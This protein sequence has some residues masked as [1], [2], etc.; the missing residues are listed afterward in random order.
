M[1]ARER[2]L[3]V[4][5][6]AVVIALFVVFI[7]KGAIL[8]PLDELRDQI[9]AQEDQRRNLKRDIGT[10]QAVSKKI[11]DLS[12]RLGKWQK[13]SLPEG[14]HRPEAF[15]THLTLM[16][17]E[18]QKYLS[19]LLRECNFKKLTINSP[20]WDREEPTNA[21]N[22]KPKDFRTL[23][24]NVSGE[25]ELGDIV[26]FFTKFY[27]TNLLH[28]IKSF[29]LASQQENNRGRTVRKEIGIKK[30][31]IEVLLV[32][33]AEP[34]K[35]PGAKGNGRETLLPTFTGK[36]KDVAPKILARPAGSYAEIANRNMFVPR[37]AETII[38]TGP[39]SE[40]KDEVDL[41]VQLT[42]LSASDYYGCW[43]ARIFN[44]GNKDDSALLVDRELP[45]G[46]RYQKD[47]ADYER[48]RLGPDGDKDRPPVPVRKWEVVDR[49]KIK[50]HELEVVRIDERGVV[51]K[52]DGKLYAMQVGDS[53]KTLLEKPLD[54]KAM[55]ELGLTA[56][57]GDVLKK[58]RLAELKQNKGRQGQGWEAV[59]VNGNDGDKKKP[60]SLD[61]LPEEF[62]PPTEWAL[63]DHLGADVVKL[64]VVY[65]DKGRVVFKADKKYYAVKP[66]QN[67][68]DALAKPL[69]DADVK[70]LKLPAP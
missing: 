12:P 8:D 66:G 33:G 1:T 10:E 22:R 17:V 59:F 56:P 43:V 42:M 67:L 28:Q 9:S 23:T 60:L 14:D 70:A 40:P 30:M 34:L 29:T 47:K 31:T 27:G 4:V 5:L 49:N 35:K 15:Q 44:K 16:S 19:K 62:D 63:K 13:L 21:R 69:P 39:P 6:A 18:Y 58:V 61:T 54:K 32:R 46:T 50:L 53:I 11:A 7:A 37:A 45:K 25:A 52:I 65:L 2:K 57:R 3:A 26:K 55:E 20:Q 48:R 64:E 68:N 41:Y 51:F 38:D 36:G 24:V